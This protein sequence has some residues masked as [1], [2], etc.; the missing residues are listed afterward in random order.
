M[1]LMLGDLED[2][3]SP[4][5][6]KIVFPIFINFDDLEE[7]SIANIE[8]HWTDRHFGGVQRNVMCRPVRTEPQGCF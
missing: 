4:C 7:R 1:G 8:R 2:G 5:F 3:N 6:A